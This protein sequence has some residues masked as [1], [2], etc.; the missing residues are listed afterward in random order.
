MNRD[1]TSLLVGLLVVA[2]ALAGA[3]ALDAGTARAVHDS[4]GN[5]TLVPGDRQPGADGVSYK[6][7]AVGQAAW[8]QTHEGRGL[9]KV[10][11]MVV[12]WA[13]GSFADCT[14][15][16]AEAFGFD[17]G[18]NDSGTT[19]DDF[20]GQYVEDFSFG[21]N[22]MWMDFYEEG[23]PGPA[24]AFRRHDQFVAHQTDCYQNPDTRGWY[25][26]FGWMNGTDF[27]GE[28]GRAELFSHYFYICDCASREEARATLGPPPSASTP[29]PTATPAGTTAPGTAAETP[30]VTPTPTATPAGTTYPDRDT[31]TST[32]V[33]TT[34][35]GPAATPTGTPAMT[36]AGDGGGET[37]PTSTGQPGFGL[38]VAI[39][40]LLLG[41]LGLLGRD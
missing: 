11:Y 1:G 15:F 33:D 10:D 2:A 23:D 9:E 24:T 20:A 26:V 40:G 25:R 31:P 18:N 17:R 5:W 16:N 38:V 35:P 30:T 13:E 32:P 7:F 4:P 34:A 8:D 39:V 22:K 6:Q 37:T 14:L 3:V 27:A 21:E 36:T 41:A 12:T 28:H 29:T 19:T